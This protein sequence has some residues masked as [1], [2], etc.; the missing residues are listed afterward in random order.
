MR[1]NG[2]IQTVKYL[3][4]KKNYR[5]LFVYKLPSDIISPSCKKTKKLCNAEKNN[6][7]LN[8][9]AKKN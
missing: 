7:P 8:A 3:L 9:H 2:N 4:Q 1:G 5:K 6:F